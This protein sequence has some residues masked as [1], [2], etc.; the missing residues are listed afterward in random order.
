[1]R[2]RIIGENRKLLQVLIRSAPTNLDFKFSLENLE[3]FLK[4]LHFL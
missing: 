4:C 1:M 2:K 3:E